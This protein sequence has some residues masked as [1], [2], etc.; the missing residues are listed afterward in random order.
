MN[1]GL[2]IDVDTFRGTRDGLPVLRRILDARG[3]R[4]S[5]FL[6]AGPDNMGRH[7]WRLLKPA[8]LAK[9]LRSQAASIYG[10]DIV[11]RGTLWPGPV[12]HR[13]LTSH[14]RG[15]ASDGHEIGMHAW[16]HHR[17]Q[18]AADRMS[19]EAVRSEIVMA[20][21]AL[22][23][24]IGRSPT[25]TAAPGWRC[26]PGMLP[27]R[28]G[29]G[30]TY[31]SDC[32]GHGVFQPEAGPPQ[33]CVN[34]P[35]WD[36][37]VGRK[38]ITDENFNDHIRSCMRNDGF[39]VLTVH[40]ESEGGSKAAL[41]ETFLDRALADGIDIVP[42]CELIPVDVPRGRLG[43]GTVDGREGWVAVREDEPA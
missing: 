24:A 19:P 27:L 30:Y 9:M 12:I 13:R 4:A 41:F 23:E 17:W 3:I 15:A 34:L 32:R 43:R 25:C 26:T 16:D 18:V 2:R 37:A 36:E 10:W 11:L 40:A 20:H 22:T 38:T 14:L 35:T 28:E 21:E 29:L 42:L 5:V 8:F 7:L 1:L 39:D 33:V 6:T 31:A